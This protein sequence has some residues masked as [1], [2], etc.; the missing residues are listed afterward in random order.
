M[1]ILNASDKATTHKKKK[2]MLMK[3]TEE[4]YQRVKLIS[5]QNVSINDVVKEMYKMLD[6]YTSNS[7]KRCQNCDMS[8][9]VDYR[10]INNRYILFQTNTSFSSKIDLNSSAVSTGSTIRKSPNSSKLQTENHK[11]KEKIGKLTEQ[12]NSLT[13]AINLTYSNSKVQWKNKMSL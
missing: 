12:L 8:V 1:Q 11:L 2:E 3:Y 13:Q 6:F 7:S 5:G 10:N 4:L 9:T